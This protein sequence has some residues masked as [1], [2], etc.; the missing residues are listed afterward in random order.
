MCERED[1]EAGRGIERKR[2][3]EREER[4][5]DAENTFAACNSFFV[6][7]HT[8]THAHTSRCKRIFR[9]RWRRAGKNAHVESQKMT[10][11]MNKKYK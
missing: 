3:S 4:A 1:E 6:R 5:L 11:S 9:S 10:C 2:T 7:V 8:H